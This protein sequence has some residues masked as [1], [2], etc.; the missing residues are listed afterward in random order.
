MATFYQRLTI[1]ILK[2]TDMADLF[3]VRV[4]EFAGQLRAH[5]PAFDAWPQS[6]QIASLDYGFNAG[7]GGILA[8]NHFKAA[9]FA[10]D[11]KAAADSCHRATKTAEGELRSAR[12]RDLYL[13]AAVVPAV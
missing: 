11:W 2:P 6:A 13:A 5:F 3:G 12:T 4:H 1:C 8:T 9:L 7:V 10:Q